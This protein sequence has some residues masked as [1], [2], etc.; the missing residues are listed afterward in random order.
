MSILEKR[1]DGKDAEGARVVA[2]RCACPA[3]GNEEWHGVEEAKGT[4]RNIRPSE[5]KKRNKPKVRPY[6]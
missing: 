6:D 3:C 1:V 2:Q 5:A 4:D